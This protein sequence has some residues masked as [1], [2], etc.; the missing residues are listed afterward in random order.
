[1]T[2]PATI[3]DAY[4]DGSL[5][6]AQAHALRDW[7]N[8]SEANAER[9]AREVFFHRRLHDLLHGQ[10]ILD[11]EEQFR[12]DERS[13][14][15]RGQSMIMP[16]IVAPPEAEAD[17]PVVPVISPAAPKEKTVIGK[18]GW[19]KGRW[20]ASVLAVGLAACLVLAVF[21][22]QRPVAQLT[23][24]SSTG[25]PELAEQALGQRPVAQL[26]AVA[27]A[28]W[29]SD[30]GA[31]FAP[32]AEFKAGQ[33]LRLTLGAI[34]LTLGSG[35]RVTVEGPASFTVLDGNS[36]SLD[37]GKMVAHVGTAARGFSVISSNLKATDLGTEFGMSV[38][39]DGMANIEVFQGVVEVGRPVNQGAETPVQLRAGDALACRVDV[40]ALTAAPAGAIAFTRSIDQTRVPLALH[41]TGEGLPRLKQDP[42]W[43]ISAE[44]FDRSFRARPAAAGENSG[45]PVGALRTDWVWDVSNW[46]SRP[47]GIYTFRTTIDLSG[48]DPSTAIV[49]VE[50]VADDDIQ[51]ILLNGRNIAIRD[52]VK[53]KISP[54]HHVDLQGFVN[55]VN[56]IEFRVVNGSGRTGLHVEWNGT[57]APVVVVAK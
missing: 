23:A 19:L 56:V 6:P 49:H 38:S 22:R 44:S 18:R 11:I 35:A 50:A 46:L 2:D 24:G 31:A 43:V 26:T 54:A 30:S 15:P 8:E 16:A 57:A 13:E 10:G 55:G 27:G 32:G 42:H 40:G 17:E 48:F 14:D 7:L 5:S 47:A 4:M 29:D 51:Q 12:G 36:G 21:L 20:V 37:Y 1:M 25:N 28:Q 34:E 33:T 41:A 52:A 9:F 3:I 45:E 53:R 39:V